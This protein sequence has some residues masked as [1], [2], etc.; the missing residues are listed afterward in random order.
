MR[1]GGRGVRGVHYFLPGDC[2]TRPHVA[3][4]HHRVLGG[5]APWGGGGAGGG[6]RAGGGCRPLR[7]PHGAGALRVPGGPGP[8]MIRPCM[9]PPHRPMGPPTG[10]AHQGR[11]WGS[12]SL[13]W[14][15]C[16]KAG[17]TRGWSFPG[18]DA[19]DSSRLGPCAWGAAI[20]PHR[21]PFRCGLAGRRRGG[22]CPREEGV[23]LGAGVDWGLARGGSP[24]PRPGIPSLGWWENPTLEG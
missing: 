10:D 12:T 15:A 8:C 9:S 22:Y 5:G 21:P 4:A 18:A 20:I 13:V 16:G 7:Q 6:S 23:S 2:S 11:G 1:V 3:G 24:A 14:L 17:A 19:G